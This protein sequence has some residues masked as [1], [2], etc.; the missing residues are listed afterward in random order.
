MSPTYLNSQLCWTHHS[1]KLTLREFVGNKSFKIPFGGNLFIINDEA[2]FFRLNVTSGNLNLT[3]SG[4][5]SDA[6]LQVIQ[7]FNGNGIVDTGEIIK[8]SAFGETQNEAINLAGLAPGNFFI[9]VFPGVI[10]AFTSYK[11]TIAT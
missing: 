2:D 8:S 3:L 6:D 7:D 4:M 11:L 10:N 9:K 1:G 5:T